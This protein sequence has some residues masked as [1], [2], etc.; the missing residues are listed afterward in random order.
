MVFLLHTGKYKR[1]ALFYSDGK[2]LQHEGV[3]A[4]ANHQLEA[5]AYDRLCGAFNSNCFEK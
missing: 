3:I 5:L 1:V 4:N 2:I